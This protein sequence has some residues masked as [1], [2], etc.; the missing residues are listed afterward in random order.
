MGTAIIYWMAPTTDYRTVA[1][2]FGLG[3]S[4]VLGCISETT[5]NVLMDGHVFFSTGDDLKDVTN[6]FQK[7]WY[8]ANS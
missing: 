5:L 4:T 7:K 3:K 6:G 8:F 1:H 2:L